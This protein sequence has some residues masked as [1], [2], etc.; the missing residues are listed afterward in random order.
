M[1]KSKIALVLAGTMV[2]ASLLGGCGKD[3]KKTEAT[4]TEATVSLEPVATMGDAE[5]I[6]I[7]S[8]EG[9]VINEYSGEWIDESLENQRPLC[10]MINNI[11]DAMPQ[12]GIS[13]ADITYE[14]LVEGGITRFMCVFKDY[15]NIPKLGPVRSA[16]HYY[17]QL[18]CMMQGI[19]AHVGWSVYANEMIVNYGVN[20]ING[21]YDG[22]AYY[23]DESRVAPHNCYTDSEKLAET[24]ANNYGYCL[25][26]VGERTDMFAFNYEDTAIGNGQTANKVTTAFSS[27]RQPWFEYNSEDGLYYRFQY[28]EEQIDDQTGEQLKYK[29]VVVMFVSYSDLGEGLKDV[30]F[31]SGGNGY[32]FTDGEYKAI[33]WANEDSVVKYFDEN[34]E[35]LKM[36]PGKTFIT[37]FDNTIPDQIII[38]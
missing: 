13:Q 29:N 26:Y 32:Y 30:D 33:T 35:Q 36:N 25:T 19:Y 22:T 14:I 4:T 18:S 34:G 27:D 37:V 9:M 24:L 8:R 38:E 3:K 23:R 6:E 31:T 11:S 16:R 12:S 5:D 28:G 15:S 10:I 1:K 17:V 21:L 7:V 2:F 20:N